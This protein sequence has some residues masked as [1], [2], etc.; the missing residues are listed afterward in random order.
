MSGVLV[1]ALLAEAGKTAIRHLDISADERTPALHC[2]KALKNFFRL[3][4]CF[5]T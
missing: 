2:T 5:E 3:C 1:N 4:R